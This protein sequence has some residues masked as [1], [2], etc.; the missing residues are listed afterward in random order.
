MMKNSWLWCGLA[1]LAIGFLENVAACAQA[2]DV[3]NPSFEQGTNA[4]AD[5]TFSGGNGEWIADA[6]EGQRAIALAGSGQSGDSSFWRSQNL[7]LKPF[8]LYQ[9]RFQARRISGSGGCP[10][11]GPVFC[12]QDLP[13][14]PDSWKPY[15][16]VFLTPS[17]PNPENLWLRFG[18]WEVNGTVAFDAI[19]L[20]PAQA[21]YRTVNGITLGE[22]ERLDGSAYTFEAP[23]KGRS[24]NQSRS[25]AA[26]N[27]G[28]NTG[29]LLFGAGDMMT[30]LHN[31]AGQRQVS[32][33][34][35]VFIGH[36]TAGELAVEFSVDGTT[37]RQLGILGGLGSGVFDIPAD[38]LPAESVYI[39]LRYQTGSNAEL[40]ALQVHGYTYCATLESAPGDFQGATAFVAASEIDPRCDVV[41]EDLGEG[42][43]GGKNVLSF[44]LLNKSREPL[45]VRPELTLSLASGESWKA[46]GDSATLPPWDGSASAEGAPAYP[47]IALTL[48]YKIRGTGTVRAALTLGDAIRYRAETEFEVS[49]LFDSSFGEALPVSSEKVGVWWASSGWKISRPRPVPEKPGHAIRIQAARNEAEAAQLVVRPAETL[50]GFLAT[51][52][53]LIGPNGAVIPAENVDV[54]R[55]RYVPVTRPTDAVGV[56]AP[57]PDPLPPFSG[58]IDVPTNQNQP[59]WVRVRVPDEAPSGTY[60][61]F[62]HLTAEGFRADAPLEVTV[63]DFDLPNRMTCITAFGFGPERAFQYHNVTAP[64]QQREVLDKYLDALGTHHISPYNPA[65]LDPFGV[66]WTNTGGAA[67]APQFDWA[68]WDT[69]MTRAFDEY[70]FNSFRLPIVGMGGG[71]FHSRTEPSLLGHAE[72]TPE[73]QAAFRAYCQ[74]VEAHLR[75]KGWLEDAFVYWFDEPDPKDYEFVMNG[76]CKLKENAPGIHRM[77]TEQIEPALIGGPDIWCPLTPAFDPEAAQERRAAGER[78][79]WYICTGPKAPYVTLFI[80]H[81]GTELRVWLWQTWQR[82]IDGILIWET[83]YWT[84]GAAYPDPDHPQNP[85][86]DPMGWTSGY[87]TPEGVRIPWGN[88]DGRFIYPPEAAADGRPAKPVLDPPV[89]SIRFEM[90][91]DG[92][93]DY[94]YMVLLERLIEKHRNELTEAERTRYAALLEVPESITADLTH[95]TTDPAPIEAHRAAIARAIEELRGR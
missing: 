14:L 21:V 20:A 19:E 91:R 2:A 52:A 51:G 82:R 43:P 10:I 71:T 77:L 25:L 40:A 13:E 24:A 17:D 80:D 61:G 56:A 76:F 86:E 32:A 29:R 53:A 72:N 85:Y 68:A 93:E 55:V 58:P 42:V 22:G 83:N 33:Q 1:A 6:A 81:P 74:G 64:E 73:Y 49:P 87:S 30:Y 39:R 37:W 41:F 50:R 59:V 35:K 34:V 44:R 78:F 60:T 95:F 63:F 7:P 57:W 11:S 8:S 54:L 70:G 5:W 79:W 75:E 9:L 69:A 90:L 94:E 84:S 28:F 3:P 88:G 62:V 89:D 46:L 67:P 4:P 48:S 66:S 15:T 12:N 26:L 92:I 47:S 16:F 65:P 45:D 38:A 36:Y 31:V 18:Q 27:C 23:I